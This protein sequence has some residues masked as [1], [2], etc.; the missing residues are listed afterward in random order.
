MGLPPRP[1]P[2][3]HVTLR[4]RTANGVSVHQGDLDTGHGIITV[5]GKYALTGHYLPT[6]ERVTCLVCQRSLE[7][8]EAS[9]DN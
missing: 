8:Q 9:R 1:D 5:C 2:I 4:L 3:P 6:D 7:R